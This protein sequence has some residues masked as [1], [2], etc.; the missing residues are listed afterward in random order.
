MFEIVIDTGGTFTDGVLVDEEQ[1]TSLAKFAT[2]PVNPSKGILNCITRL[3]E[4]R[5]LTPEE[6]LAKTTTVTVGTT[7]PTNAI[8]E[9]RGAKC[10]LIHTKGF[11][12]T[13]ELGRTLP[14]TDIY[15][16]KVEAPSVLIPRHLRFGVEERIQYD[17]KVFTPLNEGDVVAAVQE[18]RR[19]DIEVPVICFLHSYINPVHEEMAAAIVRQEYPNVVVS[20]LILRKWIEYDRLSTATFAAYVKPLLSRFIEDLRSHLGEAAFQ[21]TL[22]FS[23]GMGDVTTPELALQNPSIVI[24]SGIATGALMGRFLA[25]QS[26]FDNVLTFDMGGT[27]TDIS[28][29]ENRTIAT[30]TEMVIGDQK[31]AVESMDTVSIGEGGGSIAWVDRLGILRV[32]PQ[33]AGAD[34]G[35]ACYGKGGELPTLTDADVVLGYIPSDYFL[36]GRVSLTPALAEAA[37]REKIGGPLKMDVVESAHAI[38]ALSE[39]IM[40]E[41]VFMSVVEKGF[42][43]RD[44]VLVAGG[45]AG[46]VHA[47]SMAKSLGIERVYIPKQAAEFSAFG[48]IVADYGYLVNRFYYRRDDQARIEDVKGLYDAMEQEAVAAFAQQGIG[49]E[50]MDISRG[51]EMRYFGQ[52]RDIDVTMPEVGTGTEYAETDLKSLVSAFHDRHRALYGWGDEKLPVTIAILKLRGISG[53]RPLRLVEREPSSESPAQALKR[54]RQAYFKDSG[55]FI[56][57]PCYYSDRLQ[58]GN[59]I[60]GPALI[61]APDTTVVV[62]PGAKLAVDAYENYLISVG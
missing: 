42:D 9:G 14:K 61:E 51:A 18:A 56:D 26:Q 13:F 6:L 25:E 62:P 41:S 19:R 52:L 48:G 28:V 27:S 59:A 50:D 31:N 58:P 7:L 1:S 35:P 4:A 57:T 40:G 47:A 32:G 5:G 46:P 43:P 45:G 34:P 23:T 36:G 55:G 39:A 29:L 53:R 24:G 49:R 2:D 60:T 38:A 20:S 54:T 12:D 10:C 16:L 3:A 21:G 30:T 22:L 15:N 17:G 44:F 33:S 11:R 37:I 8:L